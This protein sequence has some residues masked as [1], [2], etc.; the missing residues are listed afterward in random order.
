MTR[1]RWISRLLVGWF[2]WRNRIRTKTHCTLCLENEVVDQ[3]RYRNDLI[4]AN[5]VDFRMFRLERIIDRLEP[6]L[7]EAVY[8]VYGGNERVS[9]HKAAATLCISRISLVRRLCAA[10]RKIAEKLSETS[11]END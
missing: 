5:G 9:L 10:D 7:Q 3:T 2:H 11:H 8:A 6:D 1:V 4:N